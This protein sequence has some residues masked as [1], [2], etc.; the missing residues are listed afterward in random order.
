MNVLSRIVH[1][2]RT[3]PAG[4]F[5]TEIHP[6]GPLAATGAEMLQWMGQAR[7]WL[8]GRELSA[9]D[10]V[11]LIGPN[12]TRWVTTDLALL[13]EGLVVVPLY[14][15]QA[16]DELVGMMRDCDCSLVLVDDDDLRRA[17]IEAGWEGEVALIDELFT[18]VSLDAPVH[19]WSEGDVMTLIYTSGT[20]G[21]PKGV[22]LTEDNIAHMLP[23]TGEALSEMGAGRTEADRVFHYL[24]FCFAGSR[25]VLWTTLYR[26]T[27]ITI[28]TSLDRLIQEIPVAAPHYFLNVPVLLE[29]VKNGAEKKL[30]SKGVAIWGLY[31][32]S[33]AAYGRIEAGE[34]RK[35]DHLVLALGRKLMFDRIK[36]ALG[37]NIEFLICGSAPLG[38][39]T[40]QWFSMIGV[41]VLQVYGLTETTAIVTMDK[42]GR[43][44][45]G[46]VGFAIDGCELKVGEH[47]ELLV[48][49]RNIFKG[50]WG[51]PEAT[52]EALQDGWFHTGDQVE[53]SSDGRLTV[54]GRVKNVLVPSNGHN[55][56]P[57]PIEQKLMEHI[58]GLEQAVLV[59]H[60][61]P[62]LTAILTG[63]IDR[64]QVDHALHHIN[65]SLPHYKR[66][67]RFHHRSEPLT[68]EE[69]LLTANGKL[70]RKAIDQA[71]AD[72]IEAMYP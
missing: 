41:P 5:V 24:P 62:Y 33:R 26:G 64:K 1:Q 6:S 14:A 34:G 32:A 8:R 55:V 36:A 15:R 43:V 30:K 4:A 46:A 9:G 31:R 52:A 23:V 66:I 44:Q 57:E 51:R 70:K 49:G 18:G 22:M 56:P 10:R 65:E 60:G 54:I 39:D 67:R 50:Y 12:S 7:T 13:A 38:E 47:D 45:S 16:A 2:L 11:A 69:G 29:R 59:G 63:D 37:P 40:Q 72:D 71:F 19:D 68:P 21:A 53:L 61:R 25:I 28:S 3:R 17:V 58:T 20:S 48:R 35:R 27:G 42:P